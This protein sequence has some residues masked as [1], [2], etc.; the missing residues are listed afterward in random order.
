[1]EEYRIFGLWESKS[2]REA[3]IPTAGG[4]DK[5]TLLPTVHC[6]GAPTLSPANP[7]TS[8]FICHEDGRHI[9][10]ARPLALRHLPEPKW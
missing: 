4:K 6:G 8:L 7:A 5:L 1:M 2:Y 3:E 9:L 10:G